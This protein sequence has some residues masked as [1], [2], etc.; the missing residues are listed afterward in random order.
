[1][2]F[3]AIAEEDETFSLPTHF[4]RMRTYSRKMGRSSR[5]GCNASHQ[6]GPNQDKVM[7]MFACCNLIENG[8]LYLPEKADWLAEYINE[9][10]VSPYGKY[11]DQV[12][13]TSQA[14]D[15]IK[16]RYLES[17]RHTT[18]ITTVSI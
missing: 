14:L 3:P 15:W 13:S 4:G 1:M 10:T 17:G 12:D 2:R 5:S 9:L 11:D 18:T 8:L 7:R 16:R 6:P